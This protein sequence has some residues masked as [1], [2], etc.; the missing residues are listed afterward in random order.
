MT[1]FFQFLSRHW[2][3]VALFVIAFIW[4]IVE[5]ARHQGMGGARQTPQGVTDLINR[6]DGVVVDLRDH[7]A[8]NA[9]HISNSV[10]IPFAQI[11][12]NSPKLTKYKQRPVILVCAAGQQSVQAMNK[13]K[14][15]GFEKLYILS[16][17]LAAWKKANLPL[18]KT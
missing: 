2:I 10:N 11:D 8:F 7:A 3:L 9:G 13:L 12:H 4:L 14:K 18:K 6:E 16:G 17:G 1:D 5:E 15:A